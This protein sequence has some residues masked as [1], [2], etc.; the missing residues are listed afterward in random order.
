[1]RYHFSITRHKLSTD[2]ATCASSVFSVLGI[3]TFEERFSSN[4]PPD[5]HYFLG[6]ATNASVMVC[7][8]DDE[9]AVD[10]PYW[11]IVKGPV[12]WGV[13]DQTVLIDPVE[14]VKALT[15]AGL[16]VRNA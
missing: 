14:L 2:L 10:F 6:H 1:M 13:P 4:Y 12:A 16:K 7:D 3:S 8:S 5:D 15:E 11:I 9:N